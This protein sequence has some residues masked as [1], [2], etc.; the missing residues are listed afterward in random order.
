MGNR[1]LACIFLALV[2]SPGIPRERP[3]KVLDYTRA[4]PSAVYAVPAT[5]PSGIGIGLWLLCHRFEP[6]T[7]KDPPFHRTFH[8]WRDIQWRYDLA[9]TTRADGPRRM[10]ASASW[11]NKR[12][13]LSSALLSLECNPRWRSAALPFEDNFP[14][15][16][17]R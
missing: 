17:I 10:T 13:R 5:K 8:W 2:K 7:T 9:Q 4:T 11:R 3:R 6:S 16:E 15:L 1:K 12:I 14:C